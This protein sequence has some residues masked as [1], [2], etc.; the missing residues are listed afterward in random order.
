MRSA[1]ADLDAMFGGEQFSAAFVAVAG[2]PFEDI[3]DE[4]AA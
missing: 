2:E 4:A 3:E 1:L